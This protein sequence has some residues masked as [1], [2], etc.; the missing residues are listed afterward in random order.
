LYQFYGDS[1]DLNTIIE[2]VHYLEDG[3]TLGALLAVHALNRGYNAT[4][5]SY[6]LQVFDPTWFNKDTDFLIDRLQ[7]QMVFK[8]NPKLQTAASAYLDFLQLGGKIKFKDLRS[9]VITKYLEND[10]PI[11]VGLS[12]TYLYKSAREFGPNMDYDDLRGEPSGHFVLLHGYDS[13]SREVF[14]ADPIIKNPLEEGQL[15]K[16]N[17]DRV[18]NAILL[19]IVTYDANLI[20]ITP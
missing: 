3:G 8:K 14:I 10:Q 11:M 7:K 18:M 9:N 2:E 19:G 1:I 15:Y 5:Y 12:A 6:N 17:I 20:I 16:M 4:I 13:S